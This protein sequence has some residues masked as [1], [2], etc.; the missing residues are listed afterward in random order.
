MRHHP[1]A[2]IINDL[3]PSTDSPIN[4]NPCY[5][6]IQAKGHTEGPS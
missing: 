6:H 2:Q 1:Q 3:T 5:G 4:S